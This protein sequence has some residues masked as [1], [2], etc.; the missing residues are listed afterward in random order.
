MNDSR[1]RSG[2]GADLCTLYAATGY[3]GAMRLEHRSALWKTGIFDARDVASVR[4][5]ADQLLHA[6]DEIVVPKPDSVGRAAVYP[7]ARS[8]R[9]SPTRARR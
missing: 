7:F 3:I 6:R 8:S 5:S 1:E 9:P 4:P 2:S